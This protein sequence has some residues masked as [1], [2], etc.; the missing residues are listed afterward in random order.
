MDNIG[1][2]IIFPCICS[3]I[4]SIAF[5]IQFNL[6]LRHIFAA[7]LGGMLSQFIFSLMEMNVKSQLLCSFIS[8]CA[9]SLSS[10]ILA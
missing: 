9:I 10:Q 1:S 6:R 3:F 8:S 7:A 2:E 5:G 4:A